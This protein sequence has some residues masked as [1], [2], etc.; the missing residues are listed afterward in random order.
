MA[1]KWLTRARS[2]PVEYCAEFAAIPR[3]S[4]PVRFLR[5]QANLVLKGRARLPVGVRA[6]RPRR[7]QPNPGRRKRNRLSTKDPTQ[8][9]LNGSVGEP[10][11]G[12]RREC[13]D[14][15]FSTK[16]H[17]QRAF[18]GS[19]GEPARGARRECL[20]NRF[21]AK[22]STQLAF[23]GSAGEPVRGARREYLDNRLS[24]KD[25]TQRAF[26]GSAGVPVRGARRVRLAR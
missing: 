11:R 18:Y 1:R 21:S 9:A 14:N 23:N 4:S 26:N 5:A 6:D 19:A 22:D 7:S 20:D 17:T 24:A 2:L 25:P 8:L 3:E 10:V 16:D 12:A 13:L 15:R